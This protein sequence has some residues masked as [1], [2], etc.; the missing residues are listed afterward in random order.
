MSHCCHL[1]R[2]SVL[3]KEPGLSSVST[4]MCDPEHSPCLS[5]V[6]SM[7]VQVVSL[8][9]RGGQSACQ[10]W[11][12]CLS[13]VVSLGPSTPSS[14]STTG[15]VSMEISTLYCS[16]DTQTAGWQKINSQLG[17]AKLFKGNS[18]SSLTQGEQA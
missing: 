17:L 7:S 6:V 5:E 2:G 12:V 14:C 11:S 4:G 9:V 3:D 1:Q 18:L 15:G 13:E 10:K 16:G 8:S